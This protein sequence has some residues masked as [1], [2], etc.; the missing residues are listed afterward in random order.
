MVRLITKNACS[1]FSHKLM[2]VLYYYPLPFIF[3]MLSLKST[4]LVPIKSFLCFF[5]KAE[6]LG[7]SG[8]MDGLTFKFICEITSEVEKNRTT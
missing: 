7:N 8:K 3:V 5:F 6:V 4:S 2:N 1:L